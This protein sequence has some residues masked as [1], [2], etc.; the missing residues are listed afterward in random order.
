MKGVD[1]NALTDANWTAEATV[2]DQPV[3]D[4][5]NCDPGFRLDNTCSF[6]QQAGIYRITVRSPGFQTRQLAA[7]FAAKSGED[8]CTCLLGEDIDAVLVAE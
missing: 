6:G 2:D 5:T 1:G 4:I 3:P 7:R 8:C